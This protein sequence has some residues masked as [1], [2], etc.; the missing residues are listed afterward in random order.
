MA[1]HD[2]LNFLRKITAKYMS[3]RKRKEK[4][5]K[6]QIII[7]TVALEVGTPCLLEFVLSDLT[8]IAR[9]FRIHI[10]LYMKMFLFNTNVINERFFSFYYP[11]FLMQKLSIKSTG[12]NIIRLMLSSSPSKK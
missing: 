2:K 5:M 9:G 8:F 3:R 10:L 12:K 11:L 7:I 1:L 6:Q 4:Y